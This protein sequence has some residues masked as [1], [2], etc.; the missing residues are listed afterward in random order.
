MYISLYIPIDFIFEMNFKFTYESGV[1]SG[2]KFLCPKCGHRLGYARNVILSGL[3]SFYL[4]HQIHSALPFFLCSVLGSWSFGV[5]TLGSLCRS[6]AVGE[7]WGQMPHP[8][9][10]SLWGSLTLSLLYLWHL[11]C[12]V[13]IPVFWSAQKLALFFCVLF[14]REE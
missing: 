3:D 1:T 9:A 7:K 11:I 6:Q 12:F 5:Q 4:F 2:I 8:Q 13:Q 14:G 10:P